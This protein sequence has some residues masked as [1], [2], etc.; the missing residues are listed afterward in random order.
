LNQDP[1]PTTDASTPAVEAHVEWL[2]GGAQRSARFRSETL[3]KAPL[4]VVVAD[5]RMKADDAYHMACEGTAMLWRGDFQNARQ[6][7]NAMARRADKK[8][9]RTPANP[10]E[11]FLFHRQAQAQRAR[12]LGMLLIEVGADQ[13]VA[14]RRA[15]DLATATTEALGTLSEPCIVSLR[16]LLGMVGAHE[17]RRTGIE[18]KALAARIH[19][20]YGVFAPIRNEYLDLV[21]TAP[22]ADAKTAFDIGTGTGVLAMILARR[23]VEKV[24]AT[25]NEPRALVCA[26]DNIERLGYSDRIDVQAADLFPSGTADLVVCNPPW[27]PARPSSA[28]ER[29]VFDPK[30][31]MLLGFLK[32]AAAHMTKSGEAWLIL[33][34]LAERLEL[35]SREELLLA[36]EQAGLRVVG[37]IDTR[38]TH[39]KARTGDDA[40]GA[41]RAGEVTS[42]F[43]L[44]HRF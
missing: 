6:L 30:S 8:T 23:G 1:S 4:R 28:L 18:I 29:A 42:L 34:D 19:P 15:P 39:K 43:R 40:I 27:L 35:R 21:A 13:Q 16:E 2:E 9:P 36:I 14:L 44:G 25:D 37:R 26:R 11:S 3:A 32:G 22:W 33:S 12:T 38:P 5:D 20:H 31:R 41:A 24:V 17:W 10:K 7:L